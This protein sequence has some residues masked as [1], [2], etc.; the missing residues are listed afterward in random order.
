MHW[1]PHFE[2]GIKTIDDQH[3]KLFTMVHDLKAAINKQNMYQQMATSLRFIAD[4][5][6][7]HFEAEEAF[8]K[9][10]DYPNLENQQTMHADLIKQ[11]SNILVKLKQGKHLFP[12]QL[13]DFLMQWL[14]N[15]ILKEDKKIGKYILKQQQNEKQKRQRRYEKKELLTTEALNKITNLYK[16]ETISTDEYAKK[17]KQILMNYVSI[18][19]KDDKREVK[20]R[21]LKIEYFYEK[22]LITMEEERQFKA[23]L[24]KNL[25]LPDELAKRKSKKS[26]LLYLESIFQDGLISSEIHEKFKAALK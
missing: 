5:T 3:K 23:L 25:N 2:I 9:E 20:K 8:M 18:E 26:K 19:N 6:K 14:L 22:K 11:V 7:I 10:I 16:K 24:F 21:I 13:S 15:H 17:K 1:Q 4:Y 12:S